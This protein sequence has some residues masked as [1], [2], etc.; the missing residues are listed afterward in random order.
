MFS[1]EIYAIHRVKGAI[2]PGVAL[3]PAVSKYIDSS[4]KDIKVT[5]ASHTADHYKIL[6]KELSECM[7]RPVSLTAP[8]K[9][10]NACPISSNVNCFNFSHILKKV[11]S[12][13]S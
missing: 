3:A 4:I 11:C 12:K 10:P 2:G 8:Y 5:A 13:S 7:A 9:V 6:T 1:F